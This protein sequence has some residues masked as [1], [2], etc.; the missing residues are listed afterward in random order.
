MENDKGENI[1]DSP[2]NEIIEEV[3]EDLAPVTPPAEKPVET[4]EARYARLKRQ[5]AQLEKKLGIEHKQPEVAKEP[6]D[7]DRLDRLELKASKID[8]PDDQKFIIDTAKRL[9]LDVTEVINDE[10][11]QGKL[12]ANREAREAREGLPSGTRRASGVGRNDVEYYLAHPD[13]RPDD[14]ALAEKVLSAKMAQVSTA[15]RFSDNMY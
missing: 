13:L 9:K 1:I 10:F 14:Q 4:D 6:I 7:I 2:N 11:I 12:K 15:G 8:H 5:T 3:V